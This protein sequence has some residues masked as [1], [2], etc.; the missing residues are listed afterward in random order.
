MVGSVDF[1]NL[2]FEHEWSWFRSPCLHQRFIQILFLFFSS[3]IFL[4]PFSRVVWPPI[5]HHPGN[6][7]SL[8]RFN[9]F[10]RKHH[11]VTPYWALLVIKNV[12]W[13]GGWVGNCQ[14]HKF[15]IFFGR[16]KKGSNFAILWG[17]LKL[18]LPFKETLG[19]I[20]LLKY[21]TIP[22]LFLLSSLS[23]SQIW[24][25]PLLG[26]V[27]NPPTSQIR[28]K[29]RKKEGKKMVIITLV[30]YFLNEIN[31]FAK[32]MVFFCGIFFSQFFLK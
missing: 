17:K 7:I 12:G 9:F 14:W 6:R 25:S 32:D 22:K 1:L 18:N 3:Q 26:M 15:K 13:V 27:A 29:T 4:L 28:K 31:W 5:K 8:N 24:S 2:C 30:I 21:C 23:C 20:K 10:P 16:E 11:F 19:C